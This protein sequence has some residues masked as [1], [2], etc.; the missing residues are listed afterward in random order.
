MTFTDNNTND[1]PFS[2]TLGQGSIQGAP[3]EESIIKAL[4]KLDPN[5]EDPFLILEHV[6]DGGTN[7]NYLQTFQEGSGFQIECR[8]HSP[9]GT[10]THYG[11]QSLTPQKA[12]TSPQDFNTLAVIEHAL[13]SFFQSPSQLPSFTPDHQATWIDITSQ[14]SSS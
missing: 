12:K 6:K 7:A 5:Q 3:T 8:I 9:D 2:I 13:R 11:A 14:L 1:S 4:H 10:F